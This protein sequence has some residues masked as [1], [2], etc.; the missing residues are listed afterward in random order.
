ME[1]GLTLSEQFFR[2]QARSRATGDLS[3][4]LNRLSL[5]A[6]MLAAE[7]MRAGFVGKLGLTGETNVQDEQVREL[8]VI[9]NDIVGQVLDRAPMVAGFASE[10]MERVCALE[11]SEA[12]RY[13]VTVDPLDGSGNVDVDGAMGTIFGV[14]RRREDRIGEPATDEDFLRPGRD[15]VAAGY[16]LYGPSTMFVYSV[17][18][19]VNGFTLD[20]SIGTFF[21]THP[22]IRVPEG[23]GT[24]AVN[25]ANEAQWAEPT[26]AMVTAFR[27]QATDCGPRQARYSGALVADVHRTLIRGGVYMY[28]ATTSK[29][30]GKLRLLFENAPLA[31][32]VEHAGGAATTG[33]DRVLDVAP[34]ALHQRTPLFIG[35]SGDV[36]EVQR[37][38]SA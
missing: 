14:Y 29:P 6:R 7:I 24:Y 12:G 9:S 13:V 8:D 23:V 4:V 15:L 30:D 16:I 11:R 22:N 19:V 18:D 2:D 5:A 38:L 28:P 31:Y 1:S 26:R 37:Q 10:E 3:T 21:L 34:N 20:R 32:V 25:E 27:S 17:G 33:T 35:S 36:A